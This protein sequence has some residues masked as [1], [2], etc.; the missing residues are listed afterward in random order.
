M[1]HARQGLCAVLLLAL[2]AAPALSGCGGSEPT[3]ASAVAHS[4]LLGGLVDGLKREDDEAEAKEIREAAPQTREEREEAH[5]QAE[6][7]TI[8]SAQAQQAQEQE[9]G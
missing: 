8:E 1:L 3:V 7:A 5:E 4:G 2:I 9:A 6:R